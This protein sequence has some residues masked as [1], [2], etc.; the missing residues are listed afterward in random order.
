MKVQKVWVR[1]THLAQPTPARTHAGLENRQRLLRQEILDLLL[2]DRFVSFIKYPDIVFDNQLNCLWWLRGFQAPES[3]VFEQVAR[4]KVH[5]FQHWEV[6][7]AE[8]LRL[9]LHQPLIKKNIAL[10]NKMV[11]SSTLDHTQHHYQTLAI[12][13]GPQ[14]DSTQKA[15]SN[16]EV[17]LLIIPV[18]HISQRDIFSF[19]VSSALFPMGIPALQEK[20]STLYQLTMACNNERKELTTPSQAELKRYFLEGDFVRAR[21]PVLEEA[22]LQDT[23][24]GL[25]ELYQPRPPL[26]KDWL[27]IRLQESWEA[28]NPE[29]DVRKGAVAIDFGTSST[30][31]ACREQGKTTLLRVGMA[32]FFR[33]P[34]PEDYQNPT[35]MEWI[36]LPNLMAAWNAEAYR[37]LVRW[38]DFHFSH[39]ALASYRQNEADQ[40]I[41]ASILTNIKQGPL[42]DKGNQPP[43]RITDQTTGADIELCATASQMPVHGQRISVSNSD[44]LDPIELYAY[45][46]GLF[47]NNRSSGLFLEYYMTFPVTYP[48]KVK[49][50]ILTSFARGLMRSLP[51]SL[52]DS[53][54]IQMFSVREEASEPT[55]Y[56]ACALAELGIQPTA[57]GTAFA[58]FDFGGGSTDF[59]FGLYRLP[60]AKE[61]E[62]G[63]EQ[64][65]EHFG[66]SGDMYLGGENLVHHIAFLTFIH[67]LDVCRKLQVSFTSP[68]EAESFPGHELFIDR[69][70]TA[71]T[72]TTLLMAKVRHLWENF[73]WPTASESANGQKIGRRR[74]SDLIG[75]VL[76]HAIIDTDFTLDHAIPCFAE[77]DN[78]LPI[79]LE[80][81]NRKREKV[82]AQLVVDRNAINQFLVKRVGKGIYPFFIAMHQA[83]ARRGALPKEIHILQAGNASRALLVQALYAMLLQQNMFRWTPPTEGTKANPVMEEIRNS[84][85]LFDP[86][87]RVQFI[88]HRPPAG[89]PNDP[90]RPTAKTGVAIGLLK[91]IPGETLLA[92]HT[93]SRHRPTE[94]G[95]P[96][97]SAPIV[98]SL[99]ESPFHLYVGR[100][101]KGCFQPVLL[102][103]DPYGEWRELGTPTRRAFTLVFSTS[104]RSVFGA[105]PRGTPELREKTLTFRMGLERKQLFIQA[106]APTSVEI[107]LADS[108]EQLLQRPE[109][110]LARQVM[111]LT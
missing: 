25:W 64:V 78:R 10:Q 37:P 4:L 6:P 108:L 67:N 57:T 73:Q 21:L 66:A 29:R 65:I 48:K 71:Q 7:T 9:I 19:I 36:N 24:K 91:L 85:P 13:R 5:T 38:D 39:A 52:M 72:N 31:V 109:E 2:R 94:K 18:H 107:C 44:P 87:A 53:P 1:H 59:D 97:S 17:D 35:I 79:T 3:A 22:Y 89:D 95:K 63:Y 45:Y 33:K 68:P 55:A 16:E 12:G 58:V 92:L 80:L 106:V 34:T 105:L 56:A 81:L 32:D 82:S 75:D 111:D 103:N 47:I 99:Q 28:R 101:K 84:L 90:Y 30:V 74:E 49:R 27:E 51:L 20:L 102:Q 110:A 98:E 100:L 40:R 104:P 46:L 76:H 26:G 14:H 70:H 54:V 23:K 77:A 61:G 8:E 69:S 43:P 42:L 86:S 60:T 88:V 11:C 62:R 15:A 50:R 93:T 96:G 83:F 41:A